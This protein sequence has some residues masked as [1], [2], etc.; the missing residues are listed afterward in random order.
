MS[1][2]IIVCSVLARCSGL[3][4]FGIDAKANRFFGNFVGIRFR[5]VPTQRK[6]YRIMLMYAYIELVPPEL[7]WPDTVL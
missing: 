4:Q 6:T 7:E 1:F 5:S 2:R 3:L